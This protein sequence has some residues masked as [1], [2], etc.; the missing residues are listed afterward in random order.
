MAGR[1]LPAVSRRVEQYA[2]HTATPVTLRELYRWGC[3]GAAERT[4]MREYLH[5]EVHPQRPALQGAAAAALRPRAGSQHGPRHRMSL[6]SQY[7]D[8]LDEFPK[9]VDEDGERRFLELLRRILDDSVL[10]IP[11]LGEAVR[12]VREQMSEER[13][14]EFRSEISLIMDRFCIKRIGLRF[15]LEHFI[16]SSE[17]GSGV[18]D[19][20]SWLIWKVFSRRPLARASQLRSGCG[21]GPGMESNEDGGGL[22]EAQR[23]GLRAERSSVLPEPPGGATGL[24]EMAS[25]RAL[26]GN[27]GRRPCMRAIGVFFCTRT[28]NTQEV[29]ELVGEMI[30]VVPVE[31]GDTAVLGDLNTYDGLIVGA[32][33]W[34]TGAHEKRSGTSLDGHLAEIRDLQMGGKMVA[35]FGCGD[36]FEWSSNFCDAIEEIHSAFSA[37]GAKMIGYVDASSYQHA[38]SKSEVDGK[39]LG[40]PLD[41]ENQID[42]TEGRVEAW[43]RQ[44]KQEGMPL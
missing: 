22:E 28:G 25:A 29:A 37:A 13:Y 6:Y 5:T 44:L 17:A 26:H 10:V 4:H 24:L 16:E 15:L 41:Q 11:R 21:G 39:F 9:P 1:S 30:G 36:S 23:A 12:E 2:R 8:W 14:E 43:I 42:L 38:E 33:T 18:E 20:S 31:L 19:T 35:V 40:L 32:P 27:R 3:G 7:V 34:N